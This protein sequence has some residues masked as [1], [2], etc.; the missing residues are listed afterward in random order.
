MS[1]KLTTTANRRRAPWFR[2]RLSSIVVSAAL[3][4][5]STASAQQ[6]LPT[7]VNPETLNRLSVPAPDGSTG[8][9]GIVAHGSGT[10]VRWEFAPG[11]VLSE[12]AIL[13]TAREHDQPYEWSLHELEGLAV[14]LSPDVIDVV[15]NRAA[16]DSLDAEKAV[17][18]QVAREVFGAH[19]LSTETYVRARDVFGEAN[20]V[21]LVM[22]MAEYAEDAVRLTAFN[23][24]MPP[25][26]RQFLP[27]PYELPDDI[28]ADSRSRLPYLRRETRRAAPTP[29]LYGR[30][31][32]PEGTG[33]GQI[34]R[35]IRSVEALQQSVGARLVRLARMVA[36]R[37]LDDE[38]QWTFNA[39]E[40]EGDGLEAAVIDV[41]GSR[42]STA[43]LAERDRALIGLGRELLGNH[44]VRP[45]TYS[46]ALAVFGEADL[47]DFVNLFATHAGA[48][49]L[50]TAFDQRL[51]PGQR[52]TLP[53][54]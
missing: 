17:V 27:L 10:I 22:I 49:A 15:R 8:V 18:V 36:C 25:G 33:P 47:V 50:L 51:P 16:L 24:Q 19:A 42:A 11:R 28:H 46:T 14:G 2:D 35:R 30:G 6:A 32:A 5:G 9:D 54:R 29:P 1:Q 52:S 45:A 26:W 13:A 34:T 31:L 7:N 21:D 43:D 48:A 3:V 41:V 38:Y 39:L 4:A 23:Q 44:W 40:A 20:L 53:D 37:E 12:L